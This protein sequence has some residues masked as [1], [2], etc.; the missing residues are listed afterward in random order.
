MVPYLYMTCGLHMHCY[1]Y[2]YIIISENS[3]WVGFAVI[4]RPSVGGRLI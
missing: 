4:A 1:I 3:H 2:M